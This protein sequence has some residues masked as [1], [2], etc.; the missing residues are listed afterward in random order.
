MSAKH[1]GGDHHRH[2]GQAVEPVGEIDRIRGADHHQ[3]GEQQKC[4]P[5]GISTS[6]KNGTASGW[7]AGA[8]ERRTIQAAMRRHGNLDPGSLSLAGKPLLLRFVTL[9]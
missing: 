4:Q 7:P 5:S 8:G 6:L 9:R 2:D 3:G 1:A